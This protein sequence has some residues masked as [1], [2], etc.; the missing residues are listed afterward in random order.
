MP[1]NKI[2]VRQSLSG[3]SIEFN[4]LACHPVQPLN[5]LLFVRLLVQTLFR[6]YG[7]RLSGICYNNHSGSHLLSPDMCSKLLIYIN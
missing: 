1:I 6:K 4:I 7:T 2:E 5:S 3:A